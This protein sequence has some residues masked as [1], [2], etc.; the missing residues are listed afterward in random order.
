MSNQ[1]VWHALQISGLAKAWLDHMHGF[2]N[3]PFPA[4]PLHAPIEITPELSLSLA[5]TGQVSLSKAQA[6]PRTM[7]TEFVH[8]TLCSGVPASLSLLQPLPIGDLK[9]LMPLTAALAQQWLL[10][11]FLTMHAAVV[12]LPAGTVL[13]L[14]DS[15]AGKSTLIRAALS[16]G[17]RVVSDDLVR[18]S[19]AGEAFIAHNLR[20]F[21]RFRGD[22]QKAEEM[23]WIRPNDARFCESLALD[24]IV[25]LQSWPANSAGR[26]PHT[27]AQA[28]GKLEATAQLINQS[29]PLFLQ[30]SFPIERQLL[31]TAIQHML[32]KLPCIQ[33]RTGSDVMVDPERAF[34]VLTD[35]LWP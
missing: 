31:V 24:G 10:A 26:A 28:V 12:Q 11:G 29:A 27:Q 1:E 34:A 20:G 13:V 9:A 25:C 2:A 33:A 16:V 15:L 3:A 5:K 17:A 23:I 21:L 35:A 6:L 19:W 8:A 30:G 18:I 4:A 7:Q 14:G 32:A 22:E